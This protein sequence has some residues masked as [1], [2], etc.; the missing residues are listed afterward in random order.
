MQALPPAPL[1]ARR[2]LTIVRTLAHG[3]LLDWRRTRAPLLWLIF[4][5]VSAWADRALGSGI[6]PGSA[7]VTFPTAAVLGLLAGHTFASRW[8]AA[9]TVRLVLLQAARPIDVAC[10]W[11]AGA[12]VALAGA[13]AVFSVYIALRAGPTAALGAAGFALLGALGIAAFAQAIALALP[14][15]AAAVLG[16]LLVVWGLGP[17]E[18]FIPVGSPAWLGSVIAAVGWL[19][20][21]AHGAAE[22]FVGVARWLRVA[23]AASHIALGLLLAAWILARPA[24]RARTGAQE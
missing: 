5:A 21:T 8:R 19:L 9:G 2:R 17:P 3:Y 16:I 13:G 15:D 11:W 1:P 7:T 23:S 10:G 4:L 6:G 18:R 24:A 14:R 12:C 22:A 20:P